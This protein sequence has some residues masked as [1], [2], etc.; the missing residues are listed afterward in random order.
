[1]KGDDRILI[2]PI[3]TILP[4]ESSPKVTVQPSCYLDRVAKLLISQVMWH[5]QL[6]SRYHRSLRLRALVCTYI[7]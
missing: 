3:P 4:S 5:E 1:M 7:M 2:L 6:L